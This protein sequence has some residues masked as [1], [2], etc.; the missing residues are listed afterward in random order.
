MTMMKYSGGEGYEYEMPWNFLHIYTQHANIATTFTKFP[1]AMPGI[2]TKETFVSTGRRF[3]F[4][5]RKFS[6]LFLCSRRQT[7]IFHTKHHYFPWIGVCLFYTGVD[8]EIF[9]LYSS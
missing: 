7:S 3:F 5:L 9:L 4:N 6:H 8:I 2:F 1:S